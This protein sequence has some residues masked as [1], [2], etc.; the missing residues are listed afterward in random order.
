M[1][2]LE[3][4]KTG[5]S[6]ERLILRAASP[7]NAYA[8][9]AYYINNR[10]HLRRWEPAR[11][12]AFYTQ[13]ATTERLSQMAEQ[14]ARG[15]SVNLLIFQRDGG[16]LIGNCNFSNIVRGPLQACHLGFGIAA[17]YE[18][19]GLMQEAVSAG[20]RY[21]FEIYGLHRIMANHLPENQRSAQLLTRL[22]FE[23]EGLARAYLQINGEWRDHVLTALIN[24]R[25]PPA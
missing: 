7:D 10:E 4:P 24:N 17:E 11:T 20:I 2:I 19:Q 8:V 22:G 6:T 1:A 5:L 9:L 16:A 23:R 14:T 13:A 12:P 3:F 21:M 25:V 18:G 15:Q